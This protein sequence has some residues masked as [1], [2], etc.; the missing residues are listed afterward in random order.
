MKIVHGENGIGARAAIQ[1]LNMHALCTLEY[2]QQLRAMRLEIRER[3]PRNMLT[4]G[5]FIEDG[6]IQLYEV[7]RKMCAMISE[8]IGK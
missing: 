3:S 8:R 1:A 6:V 4:V 5:P 7:S 2:V